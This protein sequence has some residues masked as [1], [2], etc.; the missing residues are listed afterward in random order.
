M[1]LNY[2][3]LQA[4]MQLY[5]PTNEIDKVQRAYFYAKSAHEGQI[6]KSGEPYIIHPVAVSI[7]LATQ[8]LPATVLIAGLLHDVVED[9]DISKEDIGD[10]FGDEVS[11]I[12]EG[13]TKLGSIQGLSN[14]FVQ[15]ENHRKIILATAR[16]IRVILVKLADRVHNMRTIKYMNEAKQKLIANETLEVYAPIA[17]RLGMY[18]MKWEL[19]DLSFRCINRNA[20]DAIANKINM[21][22]SKRDDIVA[23]IVN[24]TVDYLE[25]KQIDAKIYGRTKHI[26]SIYQKLNK[27]QKDFDDLMDLFAFRII[28]D[29]IPQ[30]YMVLGAIHERYKPIPMKFKD[31]IPTPKHN[32]YQ[33]IHT[34]VLSDLGIPIEFQIR[35]KEMDLTAEYGIAS[36][37]MYKKD[38]SNESMQQEVNDR[39]VWLR[40]S[41]EVDDK[42]NAQ[43]FMTHV[44][45][46]YFAKNVIV[47]T[48][49]GDVVE[50]P[51]GS[52]VLDFAYYIHTNVGNKAVS[53]K[54][55]DKVVSLFYRL[56]I[57]DIVQIITNDLAEPAINYIAKVKTSRAKESLRKYFKD[58][59]KKQIQIEGRKT[60]I[61]YSLEKNIF[62]IKEKLE[63]D[64]IIDV[65]RAF[66]TNSLEEFYYQIG[67]AD[68]NIDD[69]I[70]YF[71]N[72][73]VILTHK[74]DVIIEGAEESG[75]Y[76]L[77]RY[78]SPIP[79]DDIYASKT[80]SLA[81]NTEYYIHRKNC[82][83]G[84]EQHEASFT[85]LSMNKSYVARIQLEIKDEKNSFYRVISVISELDYNITSL[86]FRGSVGKSA[87]GRI[88]LEIKNK[89]NLD[90]I[91]SH[92]LRLDN[93]L[94]V[95]RIIDRNVG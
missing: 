89:D 72:E 42:I 4:K 76:R 15:A 17:H 23:E 24:T 41:L 44:K 90:D 43:D 38:S 34:T 60:L 9:T 67:I 50:I 40:R 2:D 18:Q 10:E 48:P 68:L 14:D 22:R 88:S 11:T 32:M 66:G 49:K 73:K 7:I 19:E 69:I 80:I 53:A 58:A 75:N 37:W 46:D 36:H 16:D 63:S 95:E 20:Y 91:I 70:L 59:E 3:E 94:V 86:F 92:I 78:C 26:Y 81:G 77:C 61:K 12:V 28:V 33:S 29:T 5:L 54:V 83:E 65:Y 51:E 39:I 52:T 87:F 93:V 13:V 79:G 30:C 1:E 6:R 62:D 27:Q 85:S 35:T 25:E 56:E 64:D 47:Y 82:L 84:D 55:N 71:K 21:K 8:K 45:L 31:Y 57:G 74:N